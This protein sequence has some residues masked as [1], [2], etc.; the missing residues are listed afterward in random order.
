MHVIDLLMFLKMFCAGPKPFYQFL[1]VS[2][3]LINEGLFNSN[4]LFLQT[5]LHD[6][7]LISDHLMAF[8][9]ELIIKVLQI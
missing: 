9:C 6:V 1:L 7:V 4:L 5:R 3:S 2:K 8:H